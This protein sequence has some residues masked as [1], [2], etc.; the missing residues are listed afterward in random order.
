MSDQEETKVKEDHEANLEPDGNN[1][2]AIRDSSD[3]EHNEQSITSFK[4][5][6]NH[7]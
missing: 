1:A 4:E 3:S 6:F 2:L 5:I 7:H